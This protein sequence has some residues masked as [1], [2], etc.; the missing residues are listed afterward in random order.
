MP[1]TATH[2]ASAYRPS[3]MTVEEFKIAMTEACR[4][5][6]GPGFPYRPYRRV[7]VLA[8]AWER[9]LTAMNRGLDVG[10]TRARVMVLFSRS[11]KY[12]VL[13]GLNLPYSVT[14]N[15]ALRK[16]IE[17]LLHDLGDHDLAIFYYIGHGRS[18][19]P[20]YALHLDPTEKTPTPFVTFGPR[21]FIDFKRLRDDLIDRAAPNVFM[22]LDCS[23]AAGG[24]IGVKKELLAASAH[25][26]RTHGGPNG[27]SAA[28]VQELEHA[29]NSKHILTTPQLYHFLATRAI[30]R[31]N[32]DPQLVTMPHFLSHQDSAGH[33]MP[34]VLAPLFPHHD[35][36][37]GGVE[38]LFN[39]KVSV[40]LHVHLR[41]VN[42]AVFGEL[43]EWVARH[44]PQNL[45]RIEIKEVLPSVSCAVLL[46]T[47][48]DVWSTIPG[49]PDI[50]FICF[51]INRHAP[52]LRQL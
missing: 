33:R 49:H 37:P 47:T 45:M 26:A 24:G 16:G 19:L 46:K 6:W 39:T 42:K 22:L 10:S 14:A 36:S 12:E 28:L 34:I 3:G 13:A 5:Y 11:Y 17:T 43:K 1:G 44:C 8:V 21:P 32:N 2:P 35:W 48:I 4:N 30:V 52:G 41:G 40:L 7:R 23:C 15:L 20:S 27:F 18:N 51:V 31:V 29:V 38:P 25:D 9:D 50:S